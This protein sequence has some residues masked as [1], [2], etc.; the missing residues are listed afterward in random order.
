MITE[1]EVKAKPENELLEIWANQ[2]DYL[3][4]VVK[5][6]KEEIGRRG[7]DTSGIHVPT[8]EEI[9]EQ[10]EVLRD[11]NSVRILIF[12]Q[13]CAA[14]FLIFLVMVSG[15]EGMLPWVLLFWAILL[16]VL[17]MGLWKRKR[18]AI[19]SGLILQCLATAGN[20]LGTASTC[21]MTFQSD[22]PAQAAG[23]VLFA[24][25]LTGISAT[26]AVMYNRLRKRTFRRS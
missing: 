11:I 26:L 10:G 13:V 19:I 2:N 15:F 9:K 12:F 8:A 25:L 1:A 4:E 22:K 16:V 6:V 7:L 14:A 3:P 20:L 21:L 18:W 24:A 23:G 5:W 17:A